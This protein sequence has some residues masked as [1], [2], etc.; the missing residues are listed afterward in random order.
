MPGTRNRKVNRCYNTNTGN[1]LG[2]NHL[3][4]LAY[5]AARRRRK[6]ADRHSSGSGLCDKD[7]LAFDSTCHNPLHN[8]LL[9]KEKDEQHG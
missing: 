9:R 6:V 4:A 1:P 8:I 2:A 7:A 5:R 3:I